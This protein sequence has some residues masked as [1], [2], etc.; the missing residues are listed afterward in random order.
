MGLYSQAQIKKVLQRAVQAVEARLAG[1][2]SVKLGSGGAAQVFD[3]ETGGYCNRFVRQVFETALG[4]APFAWRFG[5]ARAYQT[6]AKLEPYR[7]D[8]RQR[9]PG[10][11]LGIPGDP[12]H[13]AVYLG[14][15]YG[16]GRELIAENTIST[17]GYPSRPG[18]KI[19]RWSTVAGRVT[20]IYRLGA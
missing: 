3:L 19:S 5:A 10:D 13:I 14:D 8:K 20:G 1:R 16:D 17:R 7:V 2:T 15:Y 11:I 12:G 4:L 18:T 9:Q 6:L